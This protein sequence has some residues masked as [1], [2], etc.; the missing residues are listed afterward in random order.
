MDRR[1]W[2]LASALMMSALACGGDDDATACVPGETLACLCPGSVAGVQTCLSDGSSFG[3]C[4]CLPIPTDGGVPSDGGLPCGASSCAGCCLGG[5][6]VAGTAEDACGV[7]GTT[8]DACG[9]SERCTAGA[10]EPLVTRCDSSTCSGCCSGSTCLGGSSSTACGSAGR[11][12]VDCGPD[13]LCRSGACALDPASRWDLRVVDLTVRTTNTLGEAWDTL[14]GAPDPFVQATAGT[15]VGRTATR[16][17]VFTATYNQ[18]VLSNV[19]ADAL[20]PM[21]RF[22][23]FDEDVSSNDFV[24]A[25]VYTNL[26][27]A[28]FGGPVQTLECGR[29][30]AT[31]NAGFTLRWQLVRH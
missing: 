16:S 2:F 29:D 7:G 21:L 25:C 31:S 15:N 6:C 23:V 22:D 27:D 28:T 3:T 24:G 13:R 30:A 9:G 18:T 14:G 8:C 1:R 11:M 20:A 26:S 10:C 4:N 12:C 19:R 17:D 5:V